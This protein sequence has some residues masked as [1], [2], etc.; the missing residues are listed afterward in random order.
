LGQ[1]FRFVTYNI[2]KGKGASGRRD[3][4]VGHLSEALASHRPDVMLCQEVFHGHEHHLHQSRELSRVLG[5]QPYYEPNR[6][7]RHG[8][9]GNAT[10][11]HYPVEEMRNHDITTNPI[12]R[13]GVL[14]L[15]VSLDGRPLHVFNAHLGL[16]QP[17][18]L[19]QIRRIGEIIAST[20]GNG[21]PVVLAGDFNDWTR[22]ID[23]EVIE[24]LGFVNAFGHLKGRETLTWHVRRPVFNLDRVYLRH[25]KVARAERLSGEPWNELSDHFPLW[26]ELELA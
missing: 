23:R 21:E 17:Q 7:R 2:R 10:F 13:R 8:H 25:L 20:C 26:A 6:R 4:S 12:E 15:K 18:R 19:R 5:L 16:N 9:H 22:R 11:T 24:R 14:Y 1:R 3:G